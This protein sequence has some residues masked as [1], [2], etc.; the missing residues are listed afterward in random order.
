MLTDLAIKPHAR[1]VAGACLMPP[2]SWRRRLARGRWEPP[3]DGPAAAAADVAGDAIGAWSN[4]GIACDDGAASGC[5]EFGLATTKP[6]RRAP[7]RSRGRM[8]GPAPRWCWVAVVRGLRTLAQLGCWRAAGIEPA[9]VVRLKRGRHRQVAL[10]RARIAAVEIE[11]R[12]PHWRHRHR[13]PGVSAP[14]RC[15]IGRR[16]AELHQ[17]RCGRP[18]HRTP[19]APF[20]RCCGNPLAKE[21]VAFPRQELALPCVPRQL[22]IDVLPTDRQR[23]V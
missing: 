16:A 22:A 1:L 10:R 11:R 23:R 17:R 20:L 7:A 6:P 4:D 18:C 21:L 3:P 9:L 8:I 5:A 14:N 15:L 2:S 19:A 12:A 13:R